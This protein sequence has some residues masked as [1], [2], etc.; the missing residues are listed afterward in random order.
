MW[1]RNLKK[2]LSSNLYNFFESLP[3]P[4]VGNSEIGTEQVLNENNDFVVLDELTNRFEQLP[5]VNYIALLPQILTDKFGK[6]LSANQLKEFYRIQ[7]NFVVDLNKKTE[8]GLFE[9][10]PS[11][12]K[13]SLRIIMTDTNGSSARM[14]SI[15]IL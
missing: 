2:I 7:W 1:I 3:K 6:P 9:Q 4:E 5:G 13:S 12:Q 14:K 11:V 10:A 15:V 8:D